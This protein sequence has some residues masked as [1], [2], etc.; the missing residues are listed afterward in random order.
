[1]SSTRFDVTGLDAVKHVLNTI[2]KEDLNEARKEI[3]TAS[4]AIA[5]RHLIP[6]M[7]TQA[8]SSGVPIASRMADTARARSDRIVFVKVGA[9]NPK[10]SGFKRGQSNY[11]TGMAWGSER[12]P[13]PGAR[14]NTYSVPHNARG[15][16][17]RPAVE[18]TGK[19]AADEYAA[20]LHR[21]MRKY[22]GR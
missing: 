3:R 17:V 1:M 16:W 20:M 9:V 21:I 4:K 10:L 19:S 11:R 14:E 8:S 22:G 2:A 7:K 18:A 12:G 15:Y 6:R 5:E 13:V